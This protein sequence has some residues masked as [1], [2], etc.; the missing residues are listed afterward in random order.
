MREDDIVQITPAQPGWYAY[1]ESEDGDEFLT[2]VICWALA[3]NSRTGSRYVADLCAN[4]RGSVGL[5]ATEPGFIEHRYVPEGED[6]T[7]G[8][9]R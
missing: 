1:G 3:E 9:R 6:P 5:A 4:R 2:P 8:E 7:A